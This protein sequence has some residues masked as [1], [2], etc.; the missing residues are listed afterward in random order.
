[1][2]K[3]RLRRKRDEI[4]D[5]AMNVQR[6]E[7]I[8]GQWDRGA[9]IR[10]LKK[11]LGEKNGLL[12]EIAEAVERQVFKMELGTITGPL[13]REL[14]C[15]E[16]LRRGKEEEYQRYRRLGL[17]IYDVRNII[18]AHNEAV[19]SNNPHTP[20]TTNMSLAGSIKRDYALA[21]IFSSEV[22]KAHLKGDIHLHKLDFPDRPY[23]CGNSLEYVKKYGL[24]LASSLA[25]ASPAKHADVLILHM[26]KFACMLQIHFSGAI[27]WEGVNIFLAPFLVGLSDKELYDL[28][29]LLVFE[30][31]MQNVAKGGQAVFSDINLYWEVP[32][33][34]K[35]TP[36]IGPGGKYTGKTYQD[37]EKESQRFLIA[38]MKVY[39]SGDSSGR[40]F[41]WPKPNFHMTEKF[42]QSP[43]HEEFLELASE[44]AA[45]KGNTEFFFD[46]GETARISQCCRLSFKL[47]K[48][49]LAETK[50][51]ELIRHAATSWVTV[52]LPRLA[53]EA[54]HDEKKLFTLLK[55]KMD[56]AAKAHLEKRKFIG[57]LLDLGM[58]GSLAALC[59]RQK[60]DPYPY[61]RFDRSV[62]LTTI[63]GVNE[64][65]QYHLGKELHE[66]DEALKLG[67]KI[68]SSMHLYAREQSKKL[69]MR[70][71]TEQTPAEGTS[72]RLARLDLQWF[73]KEAGQVVKGNRRSGAVYYTNS[74]Q[75]N[76]AIAMDPIERIQKEG[77]FHPL[78][79]A[80][81][82][83][84][85][86]LGEQKPD[87]K[88]I[89]NLVKKT[90][91]NTQ[92]ELIAFSPE[93]TLCIKCRQTTRGLADRCSFCRSADVDHMTRVSG[94]FS[95]T[96][97]W[98][99]GK[100]QELKDRF[101]NEGRF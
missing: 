74:C 75:L 65:V 13:V 8:I 77:L 54:S 61:F 95:L 45:E 39:L 41:F 23:C 43:G 10:S 28:A 44:V 20:E 25:L 100:T 86:W 93:F 26:I 94:F 2:N 11:E 71:C 47:D 38:L 81:A 58:T 17:P 56:L 97:R 99:K 52:N 7:Q 66:S 53:Y 67:L 82:M 46:R 101:R 29:Q 55:Q 89:A 98:N 83:T 42:W 27:G 87:K 1:M 50:K 88:A 59:T 21:E 62:E 16:L 18:L 51:P 6:S 84:H 3:V 91:F 34:Y 33:H 30:F 36:A 80:G 96:S 63:Y 4:L 73:P 85:I 31:N 24:N 90:F 78:I 40:P 49:D 64:A 72:Y 12:E 92:N 68:V 70:I 22:G 48:Q 5:R 32:D 76:N 9:I 57:K 37:Y 69:G 19:S 60:G 15:V 14:V 35:K 79:D